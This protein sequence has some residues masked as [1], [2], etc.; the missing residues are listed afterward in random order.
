MIDTIILMVGGLSTLFSSMILIPDTYKAVKS[1]KTNMSKQ[2]II[3]KFVCLTFNLGYGVLLNYKF[4]LLASIYIYISFSCQFVCNILLGC[5]KMNQN[6][7]EEY[8]PLV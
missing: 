5:I 7:N 8:I 6:K 2:Y 4:G 1:Q 3:I